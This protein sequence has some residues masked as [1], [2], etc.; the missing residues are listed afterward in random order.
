MFNVLYKH[1]VLCKYNPCISKCRIRSHFT[2]LQLGKNKKDVSNSCIENNTTTIF[3]QIFLCKLTWIFLLQGISAFFI[4][5]SIWLMKTF[6]DIHYKL[7]DPLADPDT[8]LLSLSCL[9]LLLGILGCCANCHQSKSFF[10][11]VSFFYFYV[12]DFL[13]ITVSKAFPFVVMT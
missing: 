2:A 5:V 4:Y 9:T 6:H 10:A 1:C 13:S 12:L 11:V 8:I 3:A 7:D